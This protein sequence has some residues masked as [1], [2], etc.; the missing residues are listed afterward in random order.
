VS[1][2]K[3]PELKHLLNLQIRR[4]IFEHLRR[5]VRFIC[6]PI[7]LSFGIVDY[8]YFPQFFW[9]WFALRCSFALVIIFCFEALK[10]RNIRNHY[11]QHIVVLATT[12][13]TVV[14]NC[15]IFQSGSSV[16]V[17]GMIMAHLAGNQLLRV[18]RPYWLAGI[19]LAYVPCSF[20]IFFS[21]DPTDYKFTI[22]QSCFLGT[23]AMLSYV[24]SS[25]E[26][27]AQSLWT[28]NRIT[29]N[30]ELT[31]LN[32]SEFLK[33]NFPPGLRAKIEDGSLKLNRHKIVDGALV[34]FADISSSTSIANNVDLMTDWQVKELFLEAATR[35]ATECGLIVLTHT[36]DG[37]LFLANYDDAKDKSFEVSAFFEN[38]SEDYRK[39]A[40]AKLSPILAL[41]TGVKCGVAMGPTVVGFIGQDQSYFTAV[42]PDVNLA[43]RLCSKANPNELV[44]SSRVWYVLR[45][46]LVNWETQ[47]RLHTNLKGFKLDIPAFHLQKRAALETKAA[48]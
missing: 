7:F 26:S 10:I 21:S 14:V 37:F 13:V 5:E 15:M 28:R 42:G 23:G 18:S 44:V 47:E 8:F 31:K 32:R 9:T 30:H 45:E 6:V 22:L 19:L 24:F 39:I 27:F 48:A 29:M 34:G 17:T 38:L 41:N 33:K 16:Y 1:I 43:A 11:S 4:T 25:T 36:G 46:S 3:E 35:R 12:W 20:A 2:E 40:S